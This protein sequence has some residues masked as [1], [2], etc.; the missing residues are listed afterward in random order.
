[1]RAVAEFL[2]RG[3]LQATI[4]AMLGIPLLSPAT[5]AL[6]TLRRGMTEGLM[7]FLWALAPI[8]L[9]GVFM[10]TPAAAVWLGAMQLGIVLIGAMLLRSSVSWQTALVGIAVASAVCGLLAIGTEPEVL[11]RLSAQAIEDA[12]ETLGAEADAVDLESLFSLTSLAGVLAWA[13][14]LA[15]TLALVLGRWWQALLYNPGGLGEELRKLRLN[16]LLAGIC[17]LAWVY[18]LATEPGLAS[19]GLLAALPLLVAGLGLAH[20]LVKHRGWGG[21][22]LVAL[23]IFLV[24]QTLPVT[25]F[26]CGMALID[27][28]KDFRGLTRK[29]EQ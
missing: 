2:M 29:T 28:W 16:P 13:T 17:M 26:L 11:T 25:G 1:M 3:R 14:A 9:F 23:Y 6:V 15:S 22:P 5:V 19:W 10:E 7:I 24:I 27:S 8:V 20:W 18:C 12:R 21:G 4:V